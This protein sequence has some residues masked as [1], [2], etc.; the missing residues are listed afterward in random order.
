MAQAE[1]NVSLFRADPSE[2]D[3]SGPKV[4]VYTGSEYLD[5]RES[6]GQTAAP[7]PMPR[8]SAAYPRL[9]ARP[10]PAPSIAA[11]RDSA[12]SVVQCLTDRR[13]CPIYVCM[14][15]GVCITTG[16]KDDAECIHE[17]LNAYGSELEREGRRWAVWLS[18]T[19]A[20]EQL[21]SVLS[22]LKT[23]LEENGICL[24]TVTIDGQSYVMECAQA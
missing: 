4:P 15:Q 11:R 10:A 9:N 21:T 17:A 19:N 13:N 16:K 24:V 22:A 20:P 23:C 5:N 2:L 1:A 3:A 14:R 8:A 7:L 18:S 12:A 6:R